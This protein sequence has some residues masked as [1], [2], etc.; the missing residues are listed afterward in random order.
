MGGL[1]TFNFLD[2]ASN[3]VGERSREVAAL[4]EGRDLDLDS[5]ETSLRGQ[6]AVRCNTFG[7]TD[8]LCLR[9]FHYAIHSSLICSLLMPFF[10]PPR[11]FLSSSTAA[12]NSNYTVCKK[13]LAILRR[14]FNGE[15]KV[16]LNFLT[17]PEIIV[18]SST[19]VLRT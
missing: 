9:S 2:S 4:A 6:Q 7:A 16:V 18:F 14:G 17:I 11:S 10:S 5:R 19:Y 13:T 3:F 15:S 1:F 8:P 12:Q